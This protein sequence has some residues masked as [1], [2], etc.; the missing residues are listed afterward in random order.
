MPIIAWLILVLVAAAAGFFLGRRKPVAQPKWVPG[1]L[2][3]ATRV[4]PDPGLRWLGTAYHAMAVWAIEGV[5]A[6]QALVARHVD[7]SLR[8]EDLAG[9]EQKLMLLTGQETEG[10]ERVNSGTL[11][12]VSRPGSLGAMLLPPSASAATVGGAT[13]ELRNLA[14]ALLFHHGLLP[15]RESKSPVEP[16][17]RVTMGLAVQLERLTGS[18]AAIVINLP[19]G[20]QVMALSPQADSRR[21]LSS[22]DA[23]SPTMR[24]LKGEESVLL[25]ALDPLGTTVNDRRRSTASQVVAIGPESARI[26]AAVFWPARGQSLGSQALADV[27]EAIRDM[28]TALTTSKVVHELHQSA[29]T[30]PL[31]G[32]KNRRGFESEMAKMGSGKGALIY[33]DLDRFKA[34]NDSLG[35][36]AGD[37]ALVHFA[38]LIREHIRTSDTAARIGGEEFA[39]WLPDASA[40]VAM[41]IANR[42]RQ[43]LV[44]PGMFL[45]QGSQWPLTASYG[46]SACPETSKSLQNLPAQADAALYKAKNGGRN[47]VAMAGS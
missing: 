14:D 47:M 33:A 22:V 20:P 10:V 39:I 5:G 35:H 34:L 38:G 24:V 16:L 21:K 45:W 44:G 30:D 9:L 42:I 4:L 23:A 31:T 46:V 19:G 36:P 6:E 2:D 28:E 3:P 32:L 37:A 43:S 27:T 41:D 7:G 26:G 29:T 8:A 18:A 40:A 17:E 1:P 15:T 13:S 25:T 11:V 12:Y